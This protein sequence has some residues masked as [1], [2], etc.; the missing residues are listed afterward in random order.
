MGFDLSTLFGFAVLLHKSVYLLWFQLIGP[1]D[2]FGCQATAISSENVR[3]EWK[4][5]FNYS[6]WSIKIL[7]REIEWERDESDGF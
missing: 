2:L 3:F 1:F 4:G 7:T 5:I 6:C